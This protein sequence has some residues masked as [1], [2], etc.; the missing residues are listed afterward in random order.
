[1]PTDSPML[2]AALAASNRRTFLRRASLAS[3]A[4]AILPGAASLLTP[5]KAEAAPT[6]SPDLDI[7]ILNF[8]LNLEYLEAQYY[9]YAVQG[10]NIEAQGVSTTGGDG[11]PSGGTIV[12]SGSTVVPFTTRGMQEYA[13][14]VAQDERNHVKFLR[15]ALGG[16]AVAQPQVDLLNSFNGL[17]QLAGLG[18]SFDPF[19]SETNFLLGAFVFED[20]GVSAYRGAAPLIYNRAYIAPASGIL[21]VEAL[22]AGTVRTLLYNLNATQGQLTT[23]IVDPNPPPPNP[24]LTI[25]DMV[26]M[27]S[28]ARDNVDNLGQDKDQGILD[29]SG[30]ANIAATDK[31]GLAFARS[32]NQ[33]LRIVYGMTSA[34]KATPKSGTFFPNGLN[35]AI[36]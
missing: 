31:N 26:Q 14:E 5:S 23:N 28:D 12:K 33:V 6:P 16:A 10:T 3:V 19:E 25:A 30:N 35:G 17:A 1:M 2:S 36:R 7:A 18:N 21:A 20:V 32:T 4:G 29:N 22:H 13:E 24:D 9:T 15:T 11:T 34:T 27:I 8:A